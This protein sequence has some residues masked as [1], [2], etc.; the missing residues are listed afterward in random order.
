MQA[1]RRAAERWKDKDESSRKLLFCALSALFKLEC[2]SNASNSMDD[3][4]VMGFCTYE[5]LSGLDCSIQGF[6]LPYF[7]S[8]MIRC[9][10]FVVGHRVYHSSTNV[11]ADIATVSLEILINPGRLSVRYPTAT[12]QSPRYTVTMVELGVKDH[13]FSLPDMLIEHATAEFHLFNC[14]DL[15]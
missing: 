13:S 6:V 10:T 14:W 8:A 7:A 11:M 15:C 4:D 2:C 5:S 1:Q 9:H 12:L 3:I